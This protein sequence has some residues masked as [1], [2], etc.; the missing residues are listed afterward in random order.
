[1][2]IEWSK[3]AEAGLKQVITGKSGCPV[4]ELTEHEITDLALSGRAFGTIVGDEGMSL[5]VEIIDT[6]REMR[7]IADEWRVSGKLRS[8]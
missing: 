8:I 2:G 6:T 1:M 5:M 4:L 7:K 3:G